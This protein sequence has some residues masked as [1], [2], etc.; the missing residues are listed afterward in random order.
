MMRAG[1]TLALM[2]GLWQ[3]LILVAGLPPFL[4]PSP[5]SVAQ[6]VWL[7]RSEHFFDDLAPYSCAG[8]PVF[9]PRGQCLGMLDITGIDVRERPELMHLAQRC[10]RA[11]S[12]P[13]WGHACMQCSTRCAGASCKTWW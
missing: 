7:H 13:G 1:I 8:A 4:L 12:R 11:M 9:G 6:A 2:L 10:A 3:G 5:L